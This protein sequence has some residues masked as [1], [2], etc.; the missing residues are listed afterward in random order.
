[1]P[2]QY[3]YANCDDRRYTKTLGEMHNGDTAPETGDH[4]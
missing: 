1:M 3:T 4:Y 2:M